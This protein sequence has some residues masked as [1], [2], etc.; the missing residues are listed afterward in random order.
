MPLTSPD[1]A[2][3]AVLFDLD[4]TLLDSRAAILRSVAHTLR[5]LG[6]EPPPPPELHWFVGPPLEHGF[7][8]LLAGYGDDRVDEAVA[9]YRRHYE[10]H[11]LLD[12]PPFPGIPELLAD[13]AGSGLR[14]F[15]A[16][17]KREDFAVRAVEAFGLSRYLEAVHGAAPG[18]PEEKA[19]L[20]ARILARGGFAP[21][22]PVMVGDRE[23]DMRGAGANGVRAIGVL[24]GYGSREELAD[25]GADGIAGTVAELRGFLL[26]R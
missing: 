24:W 21:G 13:L 16:T 2:H 22:G 26:G 5:E 9:T 7:R 18:H 23:H 11:G 10:R 20:I 25:A 3:T 8:R 17:S 14:L 19:S 4:G 6:H 15:V 1:R 12:G